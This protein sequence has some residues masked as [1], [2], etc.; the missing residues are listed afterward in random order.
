MSSLFFSQSSSNSSISTNKLHDMEIG[1]VDDIDQDL[2]GLNLGPKINSAKLL[3]THHNFKPIDVQTVVV[4][5][6]M[7]F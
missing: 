4:S 6:F 3:K 1:E 2:V 5:I 7:Y